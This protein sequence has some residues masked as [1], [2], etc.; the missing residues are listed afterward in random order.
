MV[1]L[2]GA[3]LL[4]AILVG[5]AVDAAPTRRSIQ[6]QNDV[7]GNLTVDSDMILNRKCKSDYLH[8]S[9]AVVEATARV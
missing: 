9:S 7:L 4:L 1:M 5:T 8:A 2:R 3:M 6:Q